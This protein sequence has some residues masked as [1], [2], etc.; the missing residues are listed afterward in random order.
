MLRLQPV[1]V[2]HGEGDID[3]LRFAT[4]ARSPSMANPSA[5]S[6]E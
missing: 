5:S 1:S 2:D 4:R 6:T 3:E